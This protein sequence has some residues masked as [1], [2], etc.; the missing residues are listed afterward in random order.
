L[1]TDY[2]MVE[3]DLIDDND[4]DI[5]RFRPSSISDRPRPAATAG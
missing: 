4:D 5:F 2:T 3:D 1:Q